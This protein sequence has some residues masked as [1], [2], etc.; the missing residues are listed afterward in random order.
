MLQILRGETSG[1][2]AARK[3]GLTVAEV[4][5]W[6]EAFLAGAENALRSRPRDEDAQRQEQVK[7]LKQK[8]GEL[9]LDNDILKEAMKTH[10][11]A[12]KPSGE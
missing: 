6:K 8:V 3:H 1:T 11:F 12:P 10:P 7:V 4:D 5:R 9:V 2:E